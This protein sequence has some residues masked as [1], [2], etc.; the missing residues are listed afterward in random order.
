MNMN[1]CNCIDLENFQCESSTEL[2]SSSDG[3]FVTKPKEK[4]IMAQT[5]DDAETKLLAQIKILEGELKEKFL[6]IF[7]STM[8]K[9]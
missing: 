2:E 6:E 8:H 7:L 9:N 4:V 3:D 1:E 5:I